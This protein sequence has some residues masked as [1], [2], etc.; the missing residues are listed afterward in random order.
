MNYSEL[1]DKICVFFGGNLLSVLQY[2][3]T[4]TSTHPADMDLLV[5]VRDKFDPRAD[6]DFLRQVTVDFPEI[7][8]DL[9][10]LYAEEIHDADNFSLDSHGCFFV[11]ILQQARVLWGTNPFL[12]MQPSPIEVARSVTR[13][14]QYYCFRARQMYIG[15]AYR[16]K[17]RNHD[18]HRKKL[19]MAMGDLLLAAG[20]QASGDVRRFFSEHFPSILS[21]KELDA[22]A[23]ASQPLLIADAISIY[24][25][26]YSLALDLSR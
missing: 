14:L 12:H 23:P 9:Q 6:L 25:K 3:S 18:F 8:F 24:E 4:L 7:H 16:S 13:K 2:G 26:L 22:M 19:I 5:V 17:D 21:R 20:I 15:E 1:T 10:L 11:S